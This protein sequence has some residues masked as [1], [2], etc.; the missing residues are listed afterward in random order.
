MSEFERC[1]NFG[2]IPD[3]PDFRDYTME[4]D[5][6]SCKLKK[7]NVTSSI[8]TMVEDLKLKEVESKTLPANIDLS[9]WCSPIENQLNLGSCTAHAAVGLVEYFENRAFGKY[10]DASRL[11]LYKVTRKLLNLTGDTGAYLRSTMGALA[12]FGLPPEKYYPYI[13]KDYDNEPDSFC[14]SLANNYKSIQY[15]RLDD[16]ST[17]EDLL[18]KKIKSFIAAGIPSMFGFT[19]YD[20]YH[21][22][23]KDGKIPFPS[24]IEKI[25]G[26]HAVVAIGYDDSIVIE[27]IRSK[28]KTIGAILIRNSWSENWGN[29]GYGWLPYEYILKGIATDWWII[30]KNSWIDTGNFGLD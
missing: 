11:F 1:Y 4:N 20:S 6:I 5:V 7:L 9:M 12:L 26:G 19:V 15:F 25:V 10:I 23:D 17:T 28:E 21:Q 22:A 16:S 27:N 3:L 18:L 14:Y 13:T 30:L 8:S 24:N 29:K 2:W